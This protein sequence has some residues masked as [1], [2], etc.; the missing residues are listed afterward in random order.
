MFTYFNYK[1]EK[2]NLDYYAKNTERN[3]NTKDNLYIELIYTFRG[4]QLNT[5]YYAFLNTWYTDVWIN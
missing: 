1:I 3:L 2:V 4:L 5:Y